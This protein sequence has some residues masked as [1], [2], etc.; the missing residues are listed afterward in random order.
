LSRLDEEDSM[1]IA[2]LQTPQ[3]QRPQP[4]VER[5]GETGSL[6]R[7]SAFSAR[8]LRTTVID[9]N[10]RL[11]HLSSSACE[12]LVLHQND[13]APDGL[14]DR[15]AKDAG[16]GSAPIVV[17]AV[18]GDDRDHLLSVLPAHIAAA[19]RRRPAPEQ[20]VI[21]VE[22]LHIDKDAHRVTVGGKDV[23]LARLEFEL[24]VCLAE[25]HERVQTRAELLAHV[26]GLVEPIRTRTVDTH[27]KRLRDK[28]GTAGRFI[29]AVR[30]VG[31]RFGDPPGDAGETAGRM[32]RIDTRDGARASATKAATMRLRPSA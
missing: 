19:M 10:L 21:D 13:C 31:Y 26:W 24:L 28:L 29:E 8:I 27:V 5:R 9:G 18:S 22:E 6:D 32:L 14:V 3:H 2:P 11:S 15:S 16:T 30:G 23:S 17:I 7:S 12:W 20:R 25:R 4:P 1:T